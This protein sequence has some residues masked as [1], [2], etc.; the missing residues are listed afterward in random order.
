MQAA[1]VQLIYSSELNALKGYQVFIT[2]LFSF[3]SGLDKA[4]TF[5]DVL[6][7]H[8]EIYERGS[9][10]S[11]S[12]GLIGQ[13]RRSLA[14]K[15]AGL[16]LWPRHE[17]LPLNVIDAELSGPVL[18]SS[19]SPSLSFSVPLSVTRFY[20]VTCS[21]RLGML[22]EALVELSRG[23]VKASEIR[24]LP[25]KNRSGVLH[26]FTSCTLVGARRQSK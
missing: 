2:V 22:R 10:D 19:V 24:D 15:L 18:S 14:Q 3:H 6:G 8:R 13:Q 23:G 5:A 11:Q 16:V 26:A 21:P 1:G 9:A 17:L 12:D 7:P 20:V 25:Q 4:V